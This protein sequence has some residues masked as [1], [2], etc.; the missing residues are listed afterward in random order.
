[1]RL[2]SITK[3]SLI[4]VIIFLIAPFGYTQ[5]VDK[6]KQ[7]SLYTDIKAR[8]VG[9]IVTILI[10]ESASGSRQSNVNSSDK[11]AL[12]ASGSI[13]GNLTDFLPLFGAS[14]QF[15]SDHQGNEATAQKDLLTGKITAVVTEITPSGN[16]ILRGKRRL[17]VNGETHILALKGT[18]RPKD[19]TSNNTVF[20]FNLA[21]VEIA[22]KK[23]GL[24]N[25]LGKPGWVARW[26]SWF[27][28]IGLGAAAYLG[29][30]AAN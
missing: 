19:I 21:N 1:M 5:T 17:E 22:Y 18:V 14:S 25:K 13:T 15:E 9:D 30:S 16:L 6:F 26:T 12:S 20:S 7:Q 8:S 2:Q 24:M 28:L 23:A 27:M 11:A 4:A 10:V 29:V 3:K